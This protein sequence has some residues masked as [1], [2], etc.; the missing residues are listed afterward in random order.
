MEKNNLQGNKKQQFVSIVAY[1]RNDS[2]K[3]GNFIKSIMPIFHDTFKQC[4]IIYVD[5]N[6]TDDSVQVIK[7]YYE[8]NP[9]DYVVNIIR[10]GHYHGMETAMNAGRDMSIGDFVY[11]FDSLYVD[12]KPETILEAYEKCIEGN[13]IVTASTDVDLLVTSRIFYKVFNKVSGL[14]SEIGQET[15]RLLSRRGINRITSMDAHIPYRKAVYLNCGLSTAKIG[16]K[17]ITGTRP[18]RITEKYER[19]NLALDSFIYFTNVVER[20]AIFGVLGISLL[21][22]AAILYALFYCTTGAHD[23][24]MMFSLISFM[25]IGFIGLFGLIVFVIKY[26]S[27]LIDMVFKNQKYLITNVDKIS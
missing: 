9:V 14:H 19:V 7:D 16:Y 26:L 22:I 25:S 1:V 23:G 8:E 2:D 3:I 24:I 5:D 17:S 6:S 21:A 11:E 18:P 12:F 4:E 27:V 15:F 20:I 10:M 13:D